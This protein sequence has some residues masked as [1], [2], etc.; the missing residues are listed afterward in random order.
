[1]NKLGQ[2]I[3]LP[4]EIRELYVKYDFQYFLNK[5]EK[6][7]FQSQQLIESYNKKKSKLQKEIK[8]NKRQTLFHI[9]GAVRKMHSGGLLPSLFEL[10]ETRKLSGIDFDGFGENWAY[11]D[12]WKKFEKRKILKS[13]IV[14]SVLFWGAILAYILTIIKILEYLKN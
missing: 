7:E 13:K 3:E 4:N 10:D 12:I 11:F 5:I 8:N 6:N 2:I 9:D 14:K 1:M